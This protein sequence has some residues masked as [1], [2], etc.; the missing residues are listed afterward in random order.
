MRVTSHGH[1]FRRGSIHWAVIATLAV[2]LPGC[3]TRPGPEVL[4]PVAIAPGVRTLQVYVATT[5]ERQS[6]SENVFTADRANALNFAKFAISVPPNHKPGEIEM[7]TNPSDP[8]TSFAVVDQAVMS[9]A[10]F[11]KA[12]AP[13]RADRRKKQKVFVFVHG[14][15]NNFQ[16]SLFR[17]AQ[18]QADAKID[19]IPILFS[20]PSQAQVAAYATDQDAASYSRDYLMTFLTMLT[21]SP[22]V[23]DILVVGHSMGAKLTADALQQLRAEGKNQVIARLGRVVLAAPDINAQTFRAQVQAIG[24]LKPPLLVLVSKD[25]G[26]LQLSSFISGSRVP[27]I[28]ALDVNNPVVQ[29]AALEAKVQV[30]DISQLESRDG[31]K[32]DQFVSVAVLYSR[33][34]QTM[35]S[36]TSAGTFV[37]NGDSATLQPVA[38][39][40]QALAQ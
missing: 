9:E 14:F 36:R 17:L 37:L 26:A 2:I 4:T 18:L 28:G 20:W 5:R 8:Q 19:G 10:D 21:R 13:Q 30:V 3:A 39:G 23:G 12:V 33:M 32:H 27:R 22:E 15:N 25:D 24:P 35:P 6:R 40:R 11:Q 16:E 29:E 31:M 7:P 38:S 1:P 34:Q